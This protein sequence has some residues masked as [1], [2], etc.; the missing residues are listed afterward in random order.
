MAIRALNGLKDCFGFEKLTVSN[1]PKALTASVYNVVDSG[2]NGNQ[3]TRK[4]AEFATISVEGDQIRY[5]LDGNNPDTTTGHLLNPNDVLF[6]NSGADIMRFRA[7]RITSDA[8]IQVS[9][10]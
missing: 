10:A 8:T 5:R 4:Y 1:T 9:Y 7:I 3:I 2:L 6:L